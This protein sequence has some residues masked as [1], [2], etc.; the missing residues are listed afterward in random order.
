[1]HVLVQGTGHAAGLVGERLVL[2]NPVVHALQHQEDG[3]DDGGV[4]P[5]GLADGHSPAFLDADP[6]VE[7]VGQQPGH[8]AEQ[9]HRN[10][11]PVDQS[12]ER[13]GEHE[14]ADVHVGLRVGGAELLLVHEQQDGLPLASHRDSGEHTD[15]HGDADH[16]EAADRLQLRLVAGH[17]VRA[18]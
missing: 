2:A 4:H 11:E 10:Q 7:V 15:H 17:H 1:M 8:P 12:D 13:Q 9:D 14:E 5:G 18:V 16:Q 6:A 3:H